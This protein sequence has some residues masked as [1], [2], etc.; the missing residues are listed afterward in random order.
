MVYV[1][2]F[3]SYVRRNDL[4]IAGLE[5]I[6]I[7]IKLCNK[8]NI[9]ITVFYRPPNSDS[10]YYSLIEDSIGLAIDSNISNIIITGDFNI[11]QL[12]PTSNRKI[13]SLCN[14]F[15]STY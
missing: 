10:A 9:L 8:R 12:N 2:D 5:C 1:E 13:N 14:H 11:N 6:L 3:I 4:E 7:Q 15:V